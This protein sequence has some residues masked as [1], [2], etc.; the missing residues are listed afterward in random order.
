MGTVLIE[1]RKRPFQAEVTE[2]GYIYTTGTNSALISNQNDCSYILNFDV[3]PVSD[4]LITP[5]PSDN[6]SAYTY[7]VPFF[8]LKNTFSRDLVIT[9]ISCYVI[10]DTD[11]QVYKNP[12]GTPNS[13]SYSE[14][15]PVNLNFKN[16]SYS[17]GDFFVGENITGISSIGDLVK[18]WRINDNDET[19]D[20]TFDGH[21]ILGQNNSI[22]LHSGVSGN[23]I[24]MSLQFHY[25]IN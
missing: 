6:P 22:I 8:Y 20:L 19:V 14:I 4:Y 9:K 17:E 11:I 5:D 13:D 7:Q 25:L 23:N 21:L 24:S 2:F 3:T 16:S 10:A 12:V 1:G 18:N 15:E